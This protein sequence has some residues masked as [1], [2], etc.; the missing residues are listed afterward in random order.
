LALY[1]SPLAQWAATP[2]NKRSGYFHYDEKPQRPLGQQ[3]DHQGRG[4]AHRRE[5][6]EAVAPGPPAA[7]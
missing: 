1:S 4:A 3:A 2:M 6:A 5:A 7:R